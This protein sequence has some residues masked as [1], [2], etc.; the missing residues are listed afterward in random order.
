MPKQFPLPGDLTAQGWKLKIRD[1]EIREPPHV[2]LIR[3]TSSWRWD[4]RSRAFMDRE[5]DPRVVPDEIVDLLRARHPEL[6]G[7]W[8][9][10]YPENPVGRTEDE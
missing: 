4:L 7:S 3:G 8:N 9:E 5:P 2:T 1:R 10:K 6:V